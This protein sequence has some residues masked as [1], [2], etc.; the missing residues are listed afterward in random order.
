[1]RF[2]NCLSY[3]SSFAIAG[4]AEEFVKSALFAA[5]HFYRMLHSCLEAR[6]TLLIA[7]LIKTQTTPRG[8]QLHAIFF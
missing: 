4:A 2:V 7:S 1:M 3:C 6:R 5:L 8:Q